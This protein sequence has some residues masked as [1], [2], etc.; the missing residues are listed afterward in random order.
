MCGFK[1]GPEDGGGHSIGACDWLVECV[2]SE[3]AIWSADF[4]RKDFVQACQTEG[5]DWTEDMSA[6]CW[7]E[8]LA[9]M[10]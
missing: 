4:V 6:S 10:S 1:E 7:R 9:K 8:L 2:A 3:R 5:A